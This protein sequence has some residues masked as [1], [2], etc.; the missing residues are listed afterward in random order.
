[1]ATRPDNMTLSL[2]SPRRT[3]TMSLTILVA[4]PFLLG[5]CKARPTTATRKIPAPQ[6]VRTVAVRVMDLH[7]TLD[8][9][10]TVRSRR[11]VKVMSRIM[12]TLTALPKKEGDRVK[13]GQA[14]ARISAPELAVRQDRLAA[15]VQ[16]LV[17]DKAYL[18]N[19]YETNRKLHT[20]GAVPQTR[21]DATRRRCQSATQG[22]KAAKAGSRELRTKRGKGVERAP[23]TGR[24][25]RWLAEPGEHVAP[26]RP[27]LL[28]GDDRLEVVVQV[29]ETDIARGIHPGTPTI[30]TLNGENAT[31]RAQKITVPVRTVAPMAKGPGRTVEVRLELPTDQRKLAR[32]GASVNV[33]FVLAHKK[34]IV[35]VPEAALRSDVS[36]ATIFIVKG[37]TL[38]AL[39]VKTGIT[40]ANWVSVRPQPPKTARVATSNLDVLRNG[41]KVYAVKT[42]GGS[43]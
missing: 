23:L 6:A 36:G 24:V 41:M 14:V 32:H 26:G 13:K 8:Y 12:G 42:Q 28:L 30:L 18:C 19:L 10:G 22:L 2:R 39:R 34:N 11:E 4:L 27:I 7:K 17:A 38:Q 9:V 37:G 43:Q 25:L 31:A 40:E 33:A 20:S 16:R 3:P 35:A 5:A 21:V 1:M 29:S 15:D